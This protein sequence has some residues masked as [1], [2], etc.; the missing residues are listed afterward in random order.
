MYLKKLEIFGFKSF[1]EKTLLEFQPGI[2]AVVG[3]NGCGKSNIFD[4]IRWV[5]GEQSMKELRGAAREDVIFNGT[6]T[7]PALGM[8]EVSLTFS[9]ESRALPVEYDEVTVSRRLYRSGESQYLLNKTIV[10]LRDVQELFMGTGVGAE[11]YSLL[12]QGKVDMVVSAKPEERRSILDEASG[13]TKYKAKKREALNKLKD[14]D[15]NLLRLNDIVTEVKRQIAS[16]ERQANK[17]RRYKEKFDKLKAMDIFYARF[18]RDDWARRTTSI[19]ERLSGLAE[20]ERVFTQEIEAVSSQLTD[21]INA[22]GELDQ[23]V[24]DSRA[25]II[26]LDGQIDLNRRQIEFGQERVATLDSEAQRM[27]AQKDQLTGRCQ[28]HQEKIDDVLREISQISQRAQTQAEELRTRKAGLTVLEEAVGAAQEEIGKN[29]ERSLGLAEAQVAS[30]NAVT[31]I[32]K[33]TQGALARQRRLEIERDKVDQEYAQI[34][35]KGNAAAAQINILEAELSRIQVERSRQLADLNEWREQ[36]VML[37]NALDAEE[38]KRIFLRSQR[39]FIERMNEQYTDMPD[40]VVEGRLIASLPPGEQKTGILGK[41][42]SVQPI[43]SQDMRDAIEGNWNVEPRTLYEIDCEMK[44][45]ELDL[46]QIDLRIDEIS[47]KIEALTEQ[48]E[49]VTAQVA[50]QE[51]RVGAVEAALREQETNCSVLRSQKQEIEHQ[52]LKI[53]EEIALIASEMSD[54][55]TAI[56]SAHQKEA[57]AQDRLLSVE[58]AIRDCRDAIKAKQAWI[59]LKM[60]EKEQIA[61]GIAQLETEIQSVQAKLQS[62]ALNEKTFSDALANA[63]QEIA[64]IAAQLQTQEGK[65]LEYETEMESAATQI[66]AIGE[67]KDRAQAELNEYLMNKEELGLQINSARAQMNSLQEEIDALKQERHEFQLDQQKAAFGEKGIKDRIAQAYKVDIDDAAVEDLRP[68]VRALISTLDAAQ[69]ENFACELED[70][71]RQCEAFGPVNLVAIDEYEELKQRFEFLTKQQADLLEAKSQLMST[72]TKINR[73][74]RQMF[75]DTFTRVSEEFR[76]YFRMLFGGG[77]AELVLLDPENVLESGIDIIARPPGKKL[78][79][80]SLLSGGEKTLTA[81]ALIFGVF[82]VN[83]SPF[84]VLDEIDA[85]L[86]ESN[87]GRFSGLLKEFAKI[88]QFIVITHNKKTMSG[89]D[90]MYGVTMPETGISRIV[91]VKFSPAEVIA[92]ARAVAAAA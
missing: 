40:A 12:P 82:K 19:N 25:R 48:M 34:V 72:I 49:I 32:V 91:S 65:R 46:G 11:A 63:V 33:E 80:I 62:L 75:M 50:S 69:M 45:V 42:K 3:P 15:N 64:A 70:L 41:I 43:V 5:L 7:N 18:Q 85:A 47:R 51:D 92:E 37:K 83:P 2:T 14:T 66:D 10:R 78:Q 77:E 54:A 44:F 79:N 35:E 29:E 36:S 55:Q 20:R 30:R 31:D 60:E 23:I 56:Q 8:C 38:K 87:V 88:S 6:Q 22:V 39:E 76:I 90:A 1:A 17:A 89:A 73:S 61:V 13:I 28:V 57:A 4:S 52:A 9:N 81:I 53:Q 67:D 84:C 86:D 27:A 59:S 74:T 21:R 24:S 58:Q 16:S 26:K 68:E 71:R